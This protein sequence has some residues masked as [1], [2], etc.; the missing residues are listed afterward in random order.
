MSYNETKRLYMDGNILFQNTKE[1]QI[2]IMEMSF[3]NSVQ[4]S[5]DYLITQIDYFNNVEQ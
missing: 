1:G 2:H 5:N 3:Y 4:M